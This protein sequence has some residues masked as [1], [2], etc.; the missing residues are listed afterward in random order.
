MKTCECLINFEPNLIDHGQGDWNLL[1]CSLCRLPRNWPTFVWS[2]LWLKLKP[3]NT[4]EVSNHF[5]SKFCLHSRWLSS[6]VS[7]AV[8]Q[9]SALRNNWKAFVKKLSSGDLSIEE[10]VRHVYSSCHRFIAHLILGYDSCYHST[11]CEQ[12]GASE[13]SKRSSLPQ[14]RI[15]GSKWWKESDPA[16][17]WSNCLLCVNRNTDLNRVSILISLWIWI[18]R[19]TVCNTLANFYPTANILN[20]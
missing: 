5:G 14:F 1:T 19:Q 12:T 18:A 13:V 11:S 20:K 2:Y 17:D 3:S 16:L 10:F 7:F 15:R 4:Y 6:S 9:V 8:L